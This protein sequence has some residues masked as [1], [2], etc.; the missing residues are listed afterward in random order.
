MDEG[1]THKPSACPNYKVQPK[2]LVKRH[3]IINLYEYLVVS[4]MRLEK[5]LSLKYLL[6]KPEAGKSG[7]ISRINI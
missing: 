6:H 7:K 5:H 3:P 1:V 4:T 2:F